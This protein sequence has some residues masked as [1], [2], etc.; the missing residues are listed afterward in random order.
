MHSAANTDAWHTYMDANKI[1]SC[2]WSVNDKKE[3][4]AFFGT[5]S[6]FNMS[7]WTNT[8]SMTSSGQ[9]IFN[10]L[11]TYANSAQWRSGSVVVTPSSSSG[12]SVIVTSSSSVSGGGV[13]A[14]CKDGSGRDY[15]CE[16]GSRA[17]YPSENPGCFAI[18]PTYSVPKGQNCSTLVSECEE[19]GYLYI[20]STE[21]EGGLCNGTRVTPAPPSSS[22]GGSKLYCDFGYET[23]AGGGCFE[24]E[25]KSECNTADGGKVATSCGR[26]DL[27]Y[28]N[29]GERYYDPYHEDCDE[30]YCG[31]CFIVPS[32]AKCRNDYGKVVSR[33]PANTL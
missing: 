11:R 17:A 20:N 32:E 16:W 22:S 5:G 18:D 27:I 7:N 2:A 21:R 25:D 14:R 29:W 24:I 6:A 4:S 30:D 13:Y 28:C 9:Y 12:G 15:F 19:Y 10:K 26:T 33:C 1:S 31:G 23:T 3:S 8:S